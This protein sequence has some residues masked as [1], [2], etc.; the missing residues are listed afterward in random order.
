MVHGFQE[1]G[2][3]AMAPAVDGVIKLQIDRLA[4]WLNTH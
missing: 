1:G 3:A 2:F 4:E